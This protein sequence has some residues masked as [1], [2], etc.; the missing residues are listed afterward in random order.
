MRHEKFL[1][2]P[3]CPIN[4]QIAIGTSVCGHL[5]KSKIEDELIVPFVQSA[6]CTESSTCATAGA[7]ACCSN[8]V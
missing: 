2:Q 8:V 4:K 3:L 5:F 7:E 1:K 6:R